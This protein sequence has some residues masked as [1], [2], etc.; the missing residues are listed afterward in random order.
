[1][2]F[3]NLNGDQSDDV[4]SFGQNGTAVTS[5]IIESANQP[6]NHPVD[7]PAEQPANQNPA[8]KAGQSVLLKHNV[9]C[10]RSGDNQ[11]LH[12]SKSAPF[13]LP[14]E[15]QQ[16]GEDE[17]SSPNGLYNNNFLAS[18]PNLFNSNSLF[19]N[20]DN[21]LKVLQTPN[22]KLHQLIDGDPQ[23]PKQIK[24]AD[25]QTSVSSSNGSS[26]GLPP[27]ILCRNVSFDYRHRKV[28]PSNVLRNVNLNCQIGSIYGLLGPSGCGGYLFWVIFFFWLKQPLT[29]SFLS[30]ARQV[31]SS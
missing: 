22:S 17:K 21:I 2:D 28:K 29:H 10:R 13:L 26:N 7:P 4:R 31:L 27:A 14:V 11:S 1:M 9:S 6:A 18:T 15:P 20:Y 19:G 24:S 25:N 8:R 16:D 5:F 3:V 23:T 30:Q 12:K